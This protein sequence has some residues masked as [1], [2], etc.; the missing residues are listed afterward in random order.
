MTIEI[1][2]TQQKGYLEV[3]VS[4]IFDLGEAIDKFPDVLSMC[5]LGNVSKAL[6]DCRKLDG[7][8]AALEKIIYAF[9]V[10]SHYLSHLSTGGAPLKVA[11]VTKIVSIYEPGVQ[12]AKDSELPFDLFS[13]IEDA[14]EWLEVAAN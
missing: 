4:G 2:F 12:I 11:Y 3:F 5:I 14:F 1:N 9:G 7:D 10:Q 6:I 8:L 13:K